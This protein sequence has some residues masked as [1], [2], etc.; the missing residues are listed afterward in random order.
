VQSFNLLVNVGVLAADRSLADEASHILQTTYASN[1]GSIRARLG[2]VVLLVT[3]KKYAE[4]IEFLNTIVLVD[5]P[6]HV[7]ALGILGS[8]MHLTGKPGWQEILKYVVQESPESKATKLLEA[9]LTDGDL[10]TQPKLV[11]DECGDLIIPNR[12]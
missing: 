5:R 8:I 10:Y 7:P 4:A 12:C 9:M 6:H 3:T 1:P 2:R 11:S